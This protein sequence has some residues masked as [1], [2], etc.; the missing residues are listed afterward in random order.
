VPPSYSCVLCKSTLEPRPPVL[1]CASCGKSYPFLVAGRVPLLVADP[2]WHITETLAALVATERRA[3]RALDEVTRL[4]AA[5]HR[6]ARA[7]ARMQR[8]IAGN[9]ALVRRWRAALAAASPG[10]AG[11]A[12]QLRQADDGMTA[13]IPTFRYFVHDWGRRP[14]NEVVIA[15]TVASLDRHLAGRDRSAVVV[16]GGGAGRLAWE[17]SRGCD[18]VQI[19]DL[20]APMALT[21][22]WLQDEEL[23]VHQIVEMNVGEV[24]ELYPE[25]ALAVPHDPTAR[26]ERVSYAVADALRMP[27]AAG[28]VSAAVSVYFSDVVGALPDL[29]REVSRVLAPG[30]AFLHFGTLGYGGFAPAEMWTAEEVRALVA[31]HGFRIEAEEWVPHALWPSTSLVQLQA[32]AW[33]FVARKM[34]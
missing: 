11:L 5:G 24:D 27:I 7:L 6:R 14:E 16:L 29:L 20:G 33:S 13:N 30:G 4:L 12:A 21:W 15:A 31:E 18:A 32:R 8:G 10:A 3:Q 1:I 23:L 17:L 19:F 22:A 25:V 9:L 2:E 26:P 28:S 34:P